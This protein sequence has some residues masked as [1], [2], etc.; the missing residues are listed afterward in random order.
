VKKGRR[1]RAYV[2]G[3]RMGGIGLREE[4]GGYKAARLSMVSRLGVGS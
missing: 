1:V 4:S 3:K 2:R